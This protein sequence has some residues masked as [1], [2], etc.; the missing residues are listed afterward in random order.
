M[1]ARSVRGTV[2]ANGGG[3]GTTPVRAGGLGFPAPLR[4]LHPSFSAARGRVMVRCAAAGVAFVLAV[5]GVVL[6]DEKGLKELAGKYTAVAVSKG[7][8]DAPAEF[9]D[10]FAAKIDGDELTL[11]VKGKA[12]PSRVKV[13]PKAKPAAID[14]SQADGPEKGKTFPGVYKTDKDELVI[15]FR[16]KDGGARPTEVS[17]KGDPGLTRLRLKKAGAKDK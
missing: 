12:F 13:D 11:T 4:K 9:L 14:I 17:D 5:G 3:R 16:E 15:V 6:A 2:A 7:G 1:V 10:G 8:K